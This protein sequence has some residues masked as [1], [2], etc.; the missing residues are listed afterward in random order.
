MVTLFLNCARDMKSKGRYTTSCF[1]ERVC[2]IDD[3][4][5]VPAHYQV[6]QG[7]EVLEPEPI[8]GAKCEFRYLQN[9]DLCKVSKY[10]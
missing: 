10:V 7:N 4:N 8:Q 9:G 2:R 5:V 1:C 6:D 3:R